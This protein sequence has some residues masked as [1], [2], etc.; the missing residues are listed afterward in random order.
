MEMKVLSRNLADLPDEIWRDI[1]ELEELAC[2]SNYG[3]VKRKA[4]EIEDARGFSY[5]LKERIQKVKLKPFYN[6]H[7]GQ[8]TYYPSCSIYIQKQSYTISIAR[9]VY[10]CFVAPFNLSDPSVL[11]IPKDHNSLNIYPENLLKVTY[12]K[13]Q[14]IIRESKRRKPEFWK[15]NGF[16]VPFYAIG[17]MS[18]RKKIHQYNLDGSYIASFESIAVA[19]Q[20]L[21]I[22]PSTISRVINGNGKTG[23]GFLWKVNKDTGQQEGEGR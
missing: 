2:I 19:A 22:A 6:T 8:H 13:F 15:N 3:R 14:E 5:T 17:Q 4:R 9:T 18:H 10:H 11:I 21:N 16:G 20:T 23:A 12:H 1:P 7:L